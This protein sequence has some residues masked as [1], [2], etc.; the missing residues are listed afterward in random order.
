MYMEISHIK[1]KVGNLCA[2]FKPFSQSPSPVKQI[3]LP[4]IHIKY[5]I[6]NTTK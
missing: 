5:N 3:G 6:S 1:T 4:Q 2:K